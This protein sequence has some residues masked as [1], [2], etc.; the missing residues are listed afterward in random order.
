MSG[1]DPFSIPGNREVRT[2]PV[3]SG[4]VS[5]RFSSKVFIGLAGPRLWR[6]YAREKGI[7]IPQI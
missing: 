1:S 3:D 4:C 7:G 2:M 6:W 5:N